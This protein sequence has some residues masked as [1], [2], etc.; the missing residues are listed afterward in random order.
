MYP[1]QKAGALGTLA[2][3]ADRTQEVG[4]WQQEQE[5]TLNEQENSLAAAK[6]FG[7]MLDAD[8]E[9]AETYY[10][11]R[12]NSADMFKYNEI[13]GTSSLK[14]KELGSAEAR[15]E[16]FPEVEEELELEMA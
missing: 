3:L 13:L 15:A 8:P 2:W 7:A 4:E 10:I 9:G 14:N 16:V 5:K 6:E 1:E 11:D 12:P